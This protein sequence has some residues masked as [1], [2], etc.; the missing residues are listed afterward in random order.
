MSARTAV[1]PGRPARGRMR[2]GSAMDETMH[3]VGNLA[4][5]W[6]QVGRPRTPAS[7]PFGAAR[8]AKKPRADYDC[9]HDAALKLTWGKTRTVLVLLSLFPMVIDMQNDFCAPGWVITWGADFRPDRRTDRAAARLAPRPWRVALRH[10]RG[11]LWV[12]LRQTG[13]TAAKPC[14]ATAST[15]TRPQGQGIGLGDGCRGHGWARRFVC[16]KTRTGWAAAVV[17]ET[18][19]LQAGDHLVDKPPHPRDYGTRP[20]IRFLRKPGARRTNPVRRGHTRTQIGVDV[21]VAPTPKLSGLRLRG[22]SAFRTIAAA[23]SQTA[24]C[25]LRQRVENVRK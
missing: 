5:T 4:C 21:H 23:T 18:G 12:Q 13:P 9:Q 22:C 7:T 20:S 14:R 2:Q 6:W 15:C 17:D 24:F 10:G 8:H 16:N 19:D 1:E 11:W 25:P 3:K